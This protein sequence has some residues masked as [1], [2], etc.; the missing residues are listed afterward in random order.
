MKTVIAGGTVVTG[1]GVIAADVVVENG[2]IA[3]LTRTADIQEGDAVID[4]AG[5]LVLPG[6]ID[7]H[8]HLSNTERDDF[9]SG[10]IAAAVGGTTSLINMTAPA[11]GQS[12][13]EYLADWQ[14]KA[15]RSVLDYS[16]HFIVP[17]SDFRE[18]L[19][20]EMPLLKE[21]GIASV[22]IFMAYKGDT[23]VDDAQTYKVMKRAAELGLTVAV[24]AENGDVI[25][26]LIR[27]YV[28]QGKVEPWYHAASRPPSM[29]AE[30]VAR[31]ASIA[32]L[33][34]ARLYI[35]H[36]SCA[37]ALE[38]V[39]RARRRGVDVIVETCPQYLLLDESYLRLPHFEGGKYVCSP[40]LRAKWNQE[41]L[42]EGIRNGTISVVGSDHC[43]YDFQGHK[44]QGVDNFANIPNGVPGIEDRFLLMY[45]YGVV[46]GRISLPRFAD[47]VSGQPARTFGM[48]SKGAIEVGKDADIVI[49]DPNR[50][51]RISKD[52]QKQEND[53][54]L[55]EGMTI[56]GAI[57]LVLSRGEV[58]VSN[59]EYI[60]GGG[61]GKM[62]RREA[63]SCKPGREH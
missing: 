61:R 26:E 12:I 2:R 20:E 10:T 56:R 13:P 19:L 48:T 57:D 22:K 24:H 14:A 52:R 3:G 46:E 30:A 15:G 17:G 34:G 27:G 53:Y 7:V 25:D 54:N 21:Q 6:G 32:E 35:V 29:E 58:I 4:A 11:P 43:S 18:S 23:M 8:T 41:P 16:F 38:E 1:A 42:W 28:S 51:W 59:G 36:L 62:I 50:E 5:S 47:I 44:T 39:E 37:A 31:A 9:E 33:T 60:G 45:H 55:Y 63:A 40:P 49:L